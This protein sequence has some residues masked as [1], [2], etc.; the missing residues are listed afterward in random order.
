MENITF[1]PDLYVL[2]FLLLSYLQC[3]NIS[4]Q[5][6]YYLVDYVIQC[7]VTEEWTFS[8][9][10]HSIPFIFWWINKYMFGRIVL[11]KLHSSIQFP[12][13]WVLVVNFVFIFAGCFSSF[14]WLLWPEV[15]QNL[16]DFHG[17]AAGVVCRQSSSCNDTLFH[18]ILILLPLCL[19]LI[20]NILPSTTN[21]PDAY[22][23]GSSDEQVH[24][25]S[26]MQPFHAFH[27]SM[28]KNTWVQF[29]VLHYV[30]QTLCN[31]ITISLFIR[32]L[33]KT[34]PCSSLR[35]SR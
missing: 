29:L 11:R 22:A 4:D 27:S 23:N 35:S 6:H 15:C 10:C 1:S 13:L 31:L 16:H 3:L 5:C 30:F 8:L 26:H 17:P 32:H 24:W 19:Y 7:R 34:S 28:W 12:P 20:Q 25:C 21:I 18:L 9:L 33:S 2:R 14:W